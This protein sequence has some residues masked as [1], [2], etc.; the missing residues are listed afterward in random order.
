MLNCLLKKQGGGFV[1]DGKGFNTPRFVLS[2]LKPNTKARI[3]FGF[4][5]SDAI[6][7]EPNKENFPACTADYVTPSV[8]IGGLEE[9]DLELSNKDG[10]IHYNNLYFNT[11]FNGNTHVN[12]KA[13]KF[14]IKEKW[15]IES[16][17]VWVKTS[18]AEHSI[19]TYSGKGVGKNGV[20]KTQL[21]KFLNGTE[22]DTNN[23][24]RVDSSKRGNTE[25]VYINWSGLKPNSSLNY[26]INTHHLPPKRKK[27]EPPRPL[28][29]KPYIFTNEK[30][31]ED[32]TYKKVFEIE[33]YGNGQNISLKDV[34]CDL[35]DETIALLKGKPNK[36][37]PAKEYEKTS[38]NSET[39][40]GSLSDLLASHGA[41]IETT[42][43]LVAVGSI[44]F[45][46]HVIG[47]KPDSTANISVE[48]HGKLSKLVL[49]ANKNGE[50]E[51]TFSYENDDPK[52]ILDLV[53]ISPT[54]KSFEGFLLKENLPL[55][56]KIQMSM[57]I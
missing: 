41:K 56:K 21:F 7:F 19:D 2:G 11:N 51:Q 16:A 30:V 20:P 22:Y 37:E 52:A 6:S 48:V 27:F 44:S 25:L 23:T 12:D 31:S 57:N 47:I 34:A 28:E 40:S 26:T 18:S 53:S 5:H 1:Y 50:A 8:T 39:S 24:I 17:D 45:N 42:P 46:L 49:K 4:A 54:I 55:K 13:T 35:S 9:P 32:G 38:F 33:R 43:G 15:I 10:E 14:T 29:E 36:E 3:E